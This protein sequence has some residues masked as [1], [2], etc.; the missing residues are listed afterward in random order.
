MDI[1]WI[2][3]IMILLYVVP[4]LFKR[5]PGKYEYPE[6]PQPMPEP[7]PEPAPMPATVAGKASVWSL[8][9]AKVKDGMPMSAVAPPMQVSYIQETGGTWQGG[10][11]S[12]AVING[13]IFAEILQPPRAMR[14]LEFARPLPGTKQHC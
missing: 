5:R 13:F 2:A 14:P 7:A 6:I 12:E 4:E 1:K 10:L 11:S 9:Q 8:P 3:L